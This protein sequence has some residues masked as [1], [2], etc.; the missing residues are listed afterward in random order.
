MKLMLLALALAAAETQAP[1]IPIIGETIDVRVV[2]V[3]V[4]A[5]SEGE[6]VSRALVTI[7]VYEA[8][9]TGDVQTLLS[10]IR[11]DAD[12][13]YEERIS[14]FSPGPDRSFRGCIVVGAEPFMSTGLESGSA[15]LDDIG[16]VRSSVP[17][18]IA[19]IDVH[20]P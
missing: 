5:T 17:P 12:G 9:C 15:R 4:V 14:V 11:P 10:A 18:P 13:R 6:P 19:E 8:G 2:N 20:L 3:E 16:F 7:R 1:E